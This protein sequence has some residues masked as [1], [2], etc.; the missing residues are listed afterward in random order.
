MDRAD[1]S[2]RSNLTYLRETLFDAIRENPGPVIES[3][4]A[5]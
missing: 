2:F 3:G 1:F 5:G 4:E